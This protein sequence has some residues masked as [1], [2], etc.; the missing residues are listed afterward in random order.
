MSRRPGL[1]SSYFLDNLQNHSLLLPTGSGSFLYGS[2]PRY[3][4]QK[5]N[6]VSGGDF[7]QLKEL[8][9]LYSSGLKSLDDFRDLCDYLE[10]GLFRGSFILGGIFIAHLL[11]CP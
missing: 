9:G 7:V 4:K 1:G 6:L 5:F 2:Q 8:S 3:L 11:F 10:K